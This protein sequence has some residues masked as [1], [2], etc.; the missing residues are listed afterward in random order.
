MVA[1]VAGAAVWFLRP[2]PDPAR[3]SRFVIPL[4]TTSGFPASPFSN[5]AISPD[6]G[7]IVYLTGS[8]PNGTLWG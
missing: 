3:P 5:L 4:T 7:Q 8:V 1:A 6:G 2:T